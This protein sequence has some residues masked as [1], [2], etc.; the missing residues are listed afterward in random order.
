MRSPVLPAIAQR[1][2]LPDGVEV[3]GGGGDAVVQTASMGITRPGDVGVTVGTAGVVAAVSPVCPDNATGSIQVSCYNAPGMWHVMGVSLSAAA[4]LQWLADILNQAPSAHEVSFPALIDLA[5]DVPAGADGLLFLPYLAGERSP[6]YAPAASGAFVGLLRMHGL[7]H[8]VRAVIEG[9]LLNMREILEIFTAHGIRCERIVASGGATRD[10]F[11]LQ[12]MADVFGTEVV[13]MT[14]SSEG[15]AYGA[16][17]VAGVG[18][19]TWTSFD[20]VY[21]TLEVSAR[22]LPD[23]ATAQRYSRIYSGYRNLF[24]DLAAVYDDIKTA[25]GNE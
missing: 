6:N 18:A 8:L 9:A 4:G 15:G 17:L 7:G 5:K 1:W 23:S 11:W 14:G 2:N 25:R 16:A 10:P 12:T 22:F 20:D 13:T 19:G 24:G 3:Y 21:D